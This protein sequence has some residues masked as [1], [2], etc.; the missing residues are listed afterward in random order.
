MKLHIFYSH[1]NVAGAGVLGYRPHW[2]D[3]EACFTN[4]LNTIDGTDIVLHVVMDGRIDD[5][6]ISRY[7]H[8]YISHEIITDHTMDSITKQVYAVVKS[9][10]L[11][12]NDLIYILENDYVHVYGWVDKIFEL[13]TSYT[14]LSYVGLYDHNDKYDN[15]LYGDLVSK[16]FTT[17]SHHWRTTVSTCGS[18]ITT[19]RIFL[20]D[21]SV[22]IGVDIPVGDH[23]KWVYLNQTRNRFLITPVPGLSTHCVET[24]TSPCIDWKAIINKQ[25][26]QNIK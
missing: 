26:E 8:R 1:Y 13:F 15:R 24:L 3:Y 11:N 21:Y 17:P 10:P 14:N 5:N 7:K 22:H 16:I 9:T 25:Y 12:D 6:W 18:Y 2:F 20:E 4:L 19:R 23:H